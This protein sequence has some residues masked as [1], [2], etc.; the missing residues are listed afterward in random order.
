MSHRF[1]IAILLLALA[2]AAP[3]S[4][5]AASLRGDGA[6]VVA[7]AALGEESPAKRKP[8]KRDG[9]SKREPTVNQMAARERQKKCAAEW[10]EAK[11][12]GKTEGLKW[13][14]YWSQCNARL[15]GKTV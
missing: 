6:I 2:M 14:K 4:A 8:R 13:P 9:A 15:K 7:Q 12:A 11:A 3:A 5:Q 1:G 10:K